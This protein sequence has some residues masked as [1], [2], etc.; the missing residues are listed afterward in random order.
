MLT[1]LEVQ[2]IAQ[3]ARLH[4]SEKE[5]AEFGEQLGSILAY[6]ETMQEVNTDDVPELQ[7]AQG[8]VNVFRS[9]EIAC[10]PEE[11][12]RAVEAFPEKE[13]HLLKVQA[14]FESRTE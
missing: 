4:I 11:R 5:R 13:G 14:V 12:D 8:S 6:V 9:D 1:D 7:H 3:L 10:D 2:K